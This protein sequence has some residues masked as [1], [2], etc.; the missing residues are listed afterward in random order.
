MNLFI[1]ATNTCFWLAC[2]V[3]EEKSYKKIYS[4]KN[5]SLDKPLALIVSDFDWLSENTDLN[6][7]QIDFLRDYKKPF[8][9]LAKTYN[10]NLLENINSLDNSH[11]YKK[12]AFRVAHNF[13]QRR[14]IMDYGPL[15]LTSAN[16]S[17]EKEIF[18]T[19]SIL[20]TFSKS[21]WT[22]IFAHKDYEI[23][24]SQKSSDIFEFVWESLDLKYLRKN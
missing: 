4:L 8:T 10:K 3:S 13:I 19:K 11:L 12:I 9:I 22:Q 24:S 18:T 5:R 7:N 6:K 2:P 14:L 16:K 15:F 20:D 23:K 1:L 21:D 17:W